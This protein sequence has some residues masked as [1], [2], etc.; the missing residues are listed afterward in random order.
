MEV[1]FMHLAAIALTILATIGVAVYSARGVNSAAGF[2]LSGRKATAP[3]VAGSIAGVIIGGGA[4]VGTAQ[5]AFQVGL[6]GWAYALG[7]GLAFFVMGLFYAKPLRRTGLETLP[8]FFTLH[9]G[10]WAGVM[11][12]VATIL[13]MLI[14][15]L[16][17]TIAAIQ[18][19]IQV[20]GITPEVSSVLFVLVVV[21]TVFFSGQKGNSLTGLIK[22]ALLWGSL[23]IGGFIAI[24][25]L[26][27]MPSDEFH[28]MFPYDPWFNLFSRGTAEVLGNI[29]SMMVG[30]LSAQAYIQALFSASDAKTAARGAFTASAIIIPIGLPIVAI[31]MFMHATHPEIIPIQ[32][33]PTFFLGYFPDWLG[34]VAIAG[35]LLAI[36]SS[37]AGMALAIGTLFASD[38]V[39][40][41][42]HVKSNSKILLTNRLTILITMVVG[43]YF[44][45]LYLNATILELNFLSMILRGAGVFVP[46]SLAVFK[47][48]WLTPKWA[49]ASICCGTLLPIISKMVLHLTI[50]PLYLGLGSSALLI[51]IGVMV[52]GKSFRQSYLAAQTA[53]DNRKE[54]SKED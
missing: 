34:G 10:K 51:I 27:S 13:S 18:I 54:E 35:I 53:A 52:S 40:N 24:K 20:L 9:Y 6:A 48:G 32:A 16:P 25:Y 46:L 19:F 50:N 21:A 14:S 37:T 49:F 41:L 43:T 26:A 22:M 45:Y 38:F 23:L 36:I 7:A 15:Q 39:G 3:R 17:G 33:L 1:S 12:G 31:G 44:S 2:S 42:M 30:I 11:V 8:Q 29:F 47:P 4:T 5:M 28:A